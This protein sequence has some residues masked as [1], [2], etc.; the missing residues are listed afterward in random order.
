MA[1]DRSAWSCPECNAPFDL[2]TVY[3]DPDGPLLRLWGMR[4]G[5]APRRRRLDGREG[6]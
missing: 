5:R 2:L 4:M 6:D 3:L 1:V